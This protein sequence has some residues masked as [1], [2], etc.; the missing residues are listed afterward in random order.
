MDLV[1]TSRSA[2]R[3]AQLADELRGGLYEVGSAAIDQDVD[4]VARRLTAL[5]ADVVIHTAGPYQGQDY[6][7]ARACIEAGC[8]YID[9]ADGRAFVGQFGRLDAAAKRAGVSLVTGASTLPGISGAV[10]DA[11]RGRFDR[12]DSI[13]TVIAPAHQTPRGPG[14]VAAVLGYC[15]EPFRS[16]REGEWKQVYGWQDLRLERFPDLGTR[17][18]GACDVPDLELFPRYVN[19]VRSVS[20]HAALEAPWEQL[21]LW[22]MAGLRRARLVRDW[23]RHARG[24]SRLSEKLIRLGST[25]GGMRV[26]LK[27]VAGDG[28]PQT[29][30]WIL[31]AENN[32]GPEIPCTPA[33]VLARKLMHG[34]ITQRGA[35]P[36]LGLFSVDEL[37]EE[38]SNFDIR[39][40]EAV[41][42]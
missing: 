36:C 20:F 2:G 6:A 25:R 33:I 3:A 41:R 21:A 23:A 34:E 28:G 40:S 9:L 26:R 18:S 37:L 1:V 19:G 12:I 8:H 32:H 29:L 17:L 30:D 7:V 14:T 35:G 10:V 4:D 13:E 22:S 42:D 15:G 24:F 27:G 11:H 5:D 16:L 31:V 39:C 38:F